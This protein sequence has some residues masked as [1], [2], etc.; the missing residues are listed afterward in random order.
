VKENTV[1]QKCIMAN[2]NSILEVVTLSQNKF[3]WIV[4]K[5]IDFLN[6]SLHPGCMVMIK[7]GDALKK[8]E[9]LQK[10]VDEEIY[11]VGIEINKNSPNVFKG[12]AVI[13]GQGKFD[14][15]KNGIASTE[16]LEFTEVY[17]KVNGFWKIVF[18]NLNT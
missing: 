2:L 6:D 18:L 11:F 4:N 12:S 7:D 15:I 8:E 14:Q 9:F 10:I 13:T 17:F 1:I 3:E 5:R 16:L